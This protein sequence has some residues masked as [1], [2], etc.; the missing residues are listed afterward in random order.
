M[1]WLQGEFENAQVEI[2]ELIDAG[3]SVLVGSIIRGRGK[4]SG[5]EADWVVWQLWTVEGRQ[6]RSGPGLDVPGRGPR[7]RRTV[8]VGRSSPGAPAAQV[9]VARCSAPF[10]VT[11][12]CSREILGRRC[13]RPSS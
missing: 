4:H 11:V 10:A 7:N 1:D 5:V 13:R 6:G 9:A 8:G 2:K 3:A 12:T